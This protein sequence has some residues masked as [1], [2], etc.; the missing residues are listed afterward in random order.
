[1]RSRLHLAVVSAVL[2][3]GLTAA[4]VWSA[5]QLTTSSSCDGWSCL[6]VFLL[7][8]TGT[9]VVASVLW[10]TALRVLGQRCA[11]LVPVASLVSS[12]V[13]ARPLSDLVSLLGTWPWLAL[14]G[15]VWAAVLGPRPVTGYGDPR[16]R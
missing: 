10:G 7:A 12:Y 2:C 3:V 13:L 1:M 9:L 4:A 11:W 15:A 6:G 16:R 5:E 8:V 14:C